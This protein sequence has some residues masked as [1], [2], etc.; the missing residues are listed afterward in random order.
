MFPAVPDCERIG[1]GLLAQPTNA[2]S[3]LV[4]VVAGAWVLAQARHS[5]RQRRALVLLA[6]AIAANAVG[7][8]LYHGE[9][10]AATRA[11]HDA[12]IVA[13]LAFV[14]VF[15]LARLTGRGWSW[16]W[17]AF[18][19]SVAIFGAVI[20]LAPALQDAVFAVLGATIAAAVLA[21]YL[22]ARPTLRGIDR[23]RLAR[24]GAIVSF[25]LAATA[26]FTGRSGAPL[27]RPESVM[28]WHA[29]WHVLAAVAMALYAYSVVEEHPLRPTTAGPPE[30]APW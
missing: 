2:L 19:A 3:S 5:P 30:R 18:A 15:E 11:V 9:V 7:G 12:A 28:Q 23:R 17:R 29:I 13:V 26:F 22:H 1:Q 25:A 4:F 10:A 14:A 24:V 20:V 16:T 6:V 8:L 27:C 21:E